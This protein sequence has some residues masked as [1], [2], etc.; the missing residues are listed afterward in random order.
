MVQQQ[1]SWSEK[2]QNGIE[3]TTD[4][5]NKHS[6]DQITETVRRS[7][8]ASLKEQNQKGEGE[9][10]HSPQYLKLTAIWVGGTFALAALIGIVVI[11][12]LPPPKTPL[13]GPRVYEGANFSFDQSLINHREVEQVPVSL[14]R[15]MDLFL[16]DQDNVYLAGDQ[17]IQILSPG[18]ELQKTISLDDVPHALALNF[19]HDTFGNNLF[20]CTEHEVVKISLD[21]EEQEEWAYFG[22]LAYLT[23]IALSELGYVFVADAG[24][25]VVH[26]L[27]TS[28]R[29]VGKI[30]ERGADE[31][32]SGFSIPSPFF[33]MEITSDGLLRICNPAKHQ[34]EAFTQDGI[35]EPPLAWGE[36]SFEIEGFCA[37]CNP[38][39]FAILSD[40]RFV[41]AEKKIPRVKIYDQQG[42]FQSVVAGEE[43]LEIMPSGE[44][45]ENRELSPLA[46]EIHSCR[47]EVD[48]RD[49]ICVLDP[50]VRM[51]RYFEPMEEPQEDAS[52][53]TNV[54]K[55]T[56]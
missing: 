52:L 41:T 50:V 40:G 22:D 25:K 1:C 2:N 29:I 42:N 27:D 49:R 45:F 15:P 30:G 6:N 55:A 16:D 4:K 28:G 39:D 24:N 23:D 43:R 56:P 33:P 20:V 46:N 10:P 48:S 19:D 36:A 31:M 9:V 35:Y 14:M 12:L 8:N 5:M 26:R 3:D 32:F 11:L 54:E 17:E 51:I 47:V 18:G 34:I 13:P 44:E 38:S 37:C 53:A 21:T 7:R